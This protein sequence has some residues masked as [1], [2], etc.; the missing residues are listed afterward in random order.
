MEEIMEQRPKVELPLNE[1]AT[2]VLQRDKAITGENGHGKYYLYLVQQGTDERAFFATAEIHQKILESGLKTGD[3]FSVRKVAVQNGKKLTT[4]V[5]FAVVEK[6]AAPAT[7]SQQSSPTIGNDGLRELMSTCLAEAVAITQ[8]VN[9]M[10]WR[11][12]DVR[13]IALTMFIQ[14]SKAA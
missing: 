2:L 4:E 10:P 13:G 11:T 9:T 14:R 7:T 12:E 8:T 1:T 5:E 6:N 3:S